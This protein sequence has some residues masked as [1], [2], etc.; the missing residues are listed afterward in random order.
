MAGGLKIRFDCI[1]IHVYL[2]NQQFVAI[3]IITIS[4][5]VRVFYTL[6]MRYTYFNILINV[7]RNIIRTAVTID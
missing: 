3:R 5:T 1:A 7:C 6:L 2:H 4:D